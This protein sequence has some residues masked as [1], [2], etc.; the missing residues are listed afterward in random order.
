MKARYEKELNR[1]NLQIETHLFYEEDYQMRMLREN[2]IAGLAKVE[3]QHINGES[4]F[5]YDVSNMMSLRKKHEMMELKS[6]DICHL[7]EI[8]IETVEEMQ[9]YFLSPDRLVLDP[10][11]IYW[12]KEKWNF[13]YL[14]VKK[15]NLN[16]AFHE[17]TEYFV[18]TLDY[19]EMEG[20][21]L[22]SFL[23][24]ETLQE[25]FNLKDIFVRYEETY[26]RKREIEEST[27]KEKGEEEEEFGGFLTDEEYIGI[28]IEN[29]QT[30]GKKTG[31]YQVNGKEKDESHRSEKTKKKPKKFFL[32]K[33]KESVVTKRPKSRWGE[34]E[35]L[36]TD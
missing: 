36:I 1:V 13:L 25:N 16:K 17:L 21:Q 24:K 29:Y 26:K 8:I 11:L 3:C 20:I 28:N 33:G 15:S 23:H 18:K 5:N 31:G 30:A 4:V 19:K 6:D 12:N 14:P 10:S 9:S 32:G 2:K 22:A 7:V 27:E 35:D 34:W